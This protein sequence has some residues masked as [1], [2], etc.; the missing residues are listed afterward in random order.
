[1]R[2]WCAFL[3]SSFS[4]FADLTSPALMALCQNGLL[5]G[6]GVARCQFI[7]HN[8]HFRRKRAHRSA[9]RAAGRTPLFD[10]LCESPAQTEH[11][12]T[13]AA[14]RRACGER[15]C[16]ALLQVRGFLS[17]FR[18]ILVEVRVLPNTSGFLFGFSHLFSF[19]SLVSICHSAE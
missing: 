9:E 5:V 2:R 13:V 17:S 16:S 15:G 8:K 18:V 14:R 4:T 11:W 3:T 19:I 7:E 12:R 6:R 1:M 10:V